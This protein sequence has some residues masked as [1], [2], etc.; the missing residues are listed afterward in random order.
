MI[1]AAVVLPDYLPAIWT[2]PEDDADFPSRRL[3]KRAFS[4]A[5]PRGDERLSESRSGKG[6]RAIW[7]QRYWEHRLR[8]EGDFA[9][10]LDYI[11]FDPVKHG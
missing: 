2:L 1:D 8:D 9:R 5:L 7:Q 11:H 10:H 3:I 6:E 4:A